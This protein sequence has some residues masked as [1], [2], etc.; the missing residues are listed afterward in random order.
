MWQR[1]ILTIMT[2]EGEMRN[3]YLSVNGMA[4]LILKI[5]KFNIKNCTH[6]FRV[7]LPTNFEIQIFLS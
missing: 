4:V 1:R 3:A 2:V 5:I 7:V 6:E